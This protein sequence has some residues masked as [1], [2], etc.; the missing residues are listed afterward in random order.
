MSKI[1][2][3]YV[4]CD[5]KDHFSVS[6]LE[7]FADEIDDEVLEKELRVEVSNTAPTRSYLFII[8]LPSL[9][10]FINI[11]RTTTLYPLDTMTSGKIPI[12]D[13]RH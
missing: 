10:S 8:S 12:E 3:S 1:G 11:I 6:E 2:P 9:Q 4:V 7:E 5:E 13:G